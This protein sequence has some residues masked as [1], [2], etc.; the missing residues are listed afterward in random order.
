MCYLPGH[1]IYAV[2]SRPLALMTF[3]VPVV[4]IALL[5]GCAAT[6]P[7]EPVDWNG[8]VGSFAGDALS[9]GPYAPGISKVVTNRDVATSLNAGNQRFESWCT[10][11][12]GRSYP[13]QQVGSN[14]EV[15]NLQA[16]LSAKVN[17]ERAQGLGLGWKPTT[18]LVCVSSPDGKTLVAAMVSE[19]GGANETKTIHGTTVNTLTRA[20][21]TSTQSAQFAAAYERKEAE[22]MSQA[23]A[24][25]RARDAYRTAETRRLQTQPNIGDR[26]SL[27]VIIDV[28]LPMVQIQYDERYRALSSR[29]PSEWVPVQSLSA[30][31]N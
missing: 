5:S 26:T 21:F 24:E 19:P 29:P 12:G 6:S 27:G 13:A 3:L 30:P 8:F 17:A 14:P 23:S 2:L 9:T 31:A 18:V 16:A 1:G 7:T 10:A 25:S 4:L 20:F 28:R 15:Y 11:H 22:R